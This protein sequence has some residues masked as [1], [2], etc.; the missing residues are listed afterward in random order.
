[1]SLMISSIGPL[2][3]S[4]LSAAS[5]LGATASVMKGKDASSSAYIADERMRN[6]TSDLFGG[7][8]PQGAGGSMDAWTRVPGGNVDVAKVGRVVGVDSSI[9]ATNV[10]SV[11]SN[12]TTINLKGC[13]STLTF[14]PDGSVLYA[15]SFGVYGIFDSYMMYNEL[16]DT[17]SSI[18]ATP[19]KR[20]LVVTMAYDNAIYILD[21]NTLK[22][23]KTFDLGFCGSKAHLTPDGKKAYLTQSV[24]VTG[25]IDMES[26]ELD[27]ISG[28]GFDFVFS[29]DGRW[30]CGR[31]P[32]EGNMT[33]F[34]TQSGNFSQIAMDGVPVRFAMDSAKDL[35][36]ATYDFG[37]NVSMIDMRTKEVT[38]VAT[39]SAG[40]CNIALT[41]DGNQLYMAD[42]NNNSVLAFNTQTHGHKRID[43]GVWPMFVTASPDSKYVF[44]SN[45]GNQ[46]T[47][48]YSS[49]S[50]IST[51]T[52][53]VVQTFDQVTSPM[54]LIVNNES[55]QLFVASYPG[56]QVFD[57]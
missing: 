27:K 21:A 13:P 6:I 23:R 18:A 37:G 16:N 26:F 33:I 30:G 24:T 11:D 34:D 12:H 17:I 32:N 38:T 48:K 53:T 2:F 1:M 25:V 55:N 29:K 5:S 36:Y 40:I 43:T 15:G 57:F 35:C 22:K 44:V 3:N 54:E 56:L 20:H 8:K 4:V 10:S 49:V 31:S 45:N 51:A 39:E 14:S 19:D 28:G 7:E 52:N 50:Q 46:I 47:G 41:P 9:L 42:L